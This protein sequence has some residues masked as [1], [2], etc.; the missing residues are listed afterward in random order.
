MRNSTPPN[1]EPNTRAKRVAA[2]LL[3]L[4][5]SVA[6]VIG[7]FLARWSGSNRSGA[8]I[9]RTNSAPVASANPLSKL[10]QVPVNSGTHP[11]DGLIAP[12]TNADSPFPAAGDVHLN[13]LALQRINEE[14]K[15]KGLPPLTDAPANAGQEVS[16]M[17]PATNAPRETP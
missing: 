3:C 4:L 17:S 7:L 11:T 2:L 6:V 10:E 9:V 5:L 12:G 16:P 8:A 13:G 1:D 14:R 15:A